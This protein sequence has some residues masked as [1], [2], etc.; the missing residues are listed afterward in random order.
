MLSNYRSSSL[1]SSET[2]F[3]KLE[4]Y[5]L[6]FFNWYYRFDISCVAMTSLKSRSSTLPT[7]L[8]LSNRLIVFRLYKLSVRF[9][10]ELH[11]TQLNTHFINEIPNDTIQLILLITS[12]GNRSQHIYD[13]VIN[14][15]LKFKF[16][17]QLLCKINDY[18]IIKLNIFIS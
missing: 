7:Q 1:T 2:Q 6:Y 17:S 13:S 3:F 4:C 16:K 8:T 5:I 14:C 18:F 12:S 9:I 15:L 11:V 10:A